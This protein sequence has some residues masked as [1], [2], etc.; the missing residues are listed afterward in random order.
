MT[1]GETRRVCLMTACAALTLSM[2]GSA[3]QQE[4][5]QIADKYKWNLADIYPSEAAW[6]T[7]KDALVAELPKIRA[8]QG[9]LGT[10][11]QKVADALDLIN[12]L[13]K[14]F[15]RLFVYASMQS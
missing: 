10:S 9:T 2:S 5:A 6:R 15:A 8:F 14:E 11:G 12:R 13:S 7:A 1:A 3:Q 4:R